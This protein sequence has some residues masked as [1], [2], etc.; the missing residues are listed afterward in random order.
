MDYMLARYYSGSLSRFTSSDP[1]VSVRKN[2]AK[3]QRWNRYTYTLNNPI[4]YYDRDGLDVTVAASARMDVV[5]AY[6]HSGEF[7]AQFNAAK[8]NPDVNVTLTRIIH[9]Y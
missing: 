6:Q 2:A 7:R 5:Y 3:P 4:K 8:S 1:A 9:E